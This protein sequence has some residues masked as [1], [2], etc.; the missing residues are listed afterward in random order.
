MRALLLVL[1]LTACGQTAELRPKPGGSLPPK[2]LAARNVPTPAQLMTP[3][4]QARPQRND[5][6]LQH[7]ETRSPDRFDLPPPG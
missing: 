1:L 6:L 4:E 3:D 5:E 2:P 7:S